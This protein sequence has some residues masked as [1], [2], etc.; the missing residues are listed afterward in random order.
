MGKHRYTV[1]AV[2]V[3]A[4]AVFVYLAVRNLDLGKLED[5]FRHAQLWP[6]L[7]I[8]IACYLLGHLVRGLRCRL[9]VRRESNLGVIAAS[10]I[11]VVGYAAN[12]VLP[13]RLGELVR[14]GMLT[15]RT[16]I[17][18]IQSLS[19]TFIERVLDGL[20]IVAMLVLGTLAGDSP[21]WIHE[22]MRWAAVLFGGATVVI[23]AAA[24]SPGLIVAA[25]SRLGNKLGPRWHDRVVSFATSVINAGACLR[26]PRDALLLMFY[27][28]VVWSFDALLFIAI[29]P[30]FG[31]PVSIQTGVIAMSVTNLGV[32]V[33]ST[34]GYIGPFQFFC[35]RALMLHGVLEPTA[36]AY[37]TVV[38]LAIFVPITIWGVAAMLLYGVEVGSTV[39]LTREARRSVKA[40]TV[41]GVSLLEIAQL[42]PPLPETPASAFMIGL[43]EAVVAVP[44][45][46][47]PPA[48]VSYA[49]SFVDGQIKALQPKLRFLFESGMT[50]F[51]F[52]TRLRY[53]RGFCNLSLAT[54][55]AWTMRWAQGR[56]AL[57]RQLFKPVRAIALLA[58]YDHDEVKR[59]LLAPP[60]A[61]PAA[62]LVRDRAAS[63]DHVGARPPERAPDEVR[64]VG[65]SG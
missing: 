48:A 15:Q 57:L 22:I 18:V 59:E 16:G 52:V 7:P 65:D 2:G 13:L 29:L 55:R 40:T 14:A 44:G 21:G 37:A 4:S 34:P 47:P 61:L 28:F 25:S 20:T 3:L 1:I 51:R 54:R 43:V 53:L 45:R 33:P 8:G 58:Y 24:Y 56:I 42:S 17:P 11:V 60:A 63:S 49:A 30:V 6:W 39:A 36:L 50:T 46:A 62:S 41:R 32:L 12:N 10:N 5:A 64:R 38:H 31:L 19:I 26:D 35:S 23:L 27:S 9:L